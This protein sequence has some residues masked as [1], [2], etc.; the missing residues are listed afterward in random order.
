MLLDHEKGEQYDDCERD[1]VGT[2][3]RATICIPSTA[4]STEIAGVIMAS[5]K[6]S[7]A[8]A[9]RPSAVR[10]PPVLQHGEGEQ[11]HSP[12]LAM[13]IGPHERTRHI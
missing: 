3:R 8:P 4:L 6:N 12:T 11:R 10:R 5:P 2:Q 1:Y 9:R 13:I 7:D